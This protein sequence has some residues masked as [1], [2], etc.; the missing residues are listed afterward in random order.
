[1][2]GTRVI[3]VIDDDPGIRFVLRKALERAGYVV[4]EAG[5][6]QVGLQRF[7]ELQPDL[8]ITDIIMPE[9]EGVETIVALRREVPSMP[10]IAMSGGGGGGADYLAMAEKLGAARTLHKPFSLA[11]A[12][13]AVDEVL[14]A[15]EREESGLP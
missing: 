9:R 14:A 2:S 12:L 6:G 10:I 4:H 3:L 15:K 11:E 13:Q 8:V 7:R 1:M 5:D